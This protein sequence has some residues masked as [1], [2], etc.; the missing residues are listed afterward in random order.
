MQYPATHWISPKI[1]HLSSF[2]RRHC[3]LLL[4]WALE[5]GRID[6]YVDVACLS[7]YLVN[8]R[9]GHLEAVYHIYAYLKRHERCAMIFDNQILNFLQADFT[10]F[11]WLDFYGDITKAIPSNAP[12]PRGN[13]VQMNIFVDANHAGNLVTRW[14][15]TGIFIHL[16]QAPIIWYSKAQKTVE[17]STFGSEFVAL[18]IAVELIEALWCK[19]HMMGVPIDGPANVFGDNGSVITNATVPSSTLK[20]KHNA[21]CYHH[22]REAVAAKTVRI[23]YIPTGSNLADMFTTSLGGSKLHEFCKNSSLS[24][25]RIRKLTFF[26][27]A[28]ISFQGLKEITLPHV[29]RFWYLLCQVL[30]FPNFFLYVFL[31]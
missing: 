23:A 18:R 20:K 2:T 3:E 11:D 22:V 21:I 1:G 5:L 16:N 12:K 17:S 4:R 15:H 6:V 10:T 28:M 27:Q 24:D 31:L 14:S 29:Y 19:L 7:H 9:Q 30:I 8:L 26:L 13:P 25:G